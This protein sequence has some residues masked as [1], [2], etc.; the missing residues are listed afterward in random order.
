MNVPGH[1]DSSGSDPASAGHFPIAAIGASAGGLQAFRILLE[2]V[3]ADTR[4]AFVLIPHLD[5]SHPSLLSELLS[6]TSKIPVRDV[7]PG[8]RVEPG[9]AHVIRPN[10]IMTIEDGRLVLIPRDV[11]RG[12]R[13]GSISHFMISLAHT[14]RERAVGVILSGTASDGSEGIEC[15]KAEGGITFAQDDSAEFREMPR[16]AIA[17]GA[18]DFVLPPE[19]IARELVRISRHPVLQRP[20]HS[21]REGS[22]QSP[23]GGVPELIFATLR[24]ATG[25]DFSSYKRSTVERRIARRM[26]ICKTDTL[27]DYARHLGV[28]PREVQHLHDEL[29]IHVTSFFREPAAFEALRASVFPRLIRDRAV[30]DSIRVWVPGCSSGEEGYSLAIALVEFL[31]ETGGGFEVQLFCTDLSER[32]IETARVGIYDGGI[33]ESVSPARLKRFFSRTEGG[34]WQISAAIR[35]RCVFAQ[36]DVT[37]DPPFSRLDLLSCRNVMIYLGPALQ[38]RVISCF[39]YALKPTGFLMLGSAESLERFPSLFVPVDLQH[40][41]FAKVHGSRVD[42]AAS[43]YGRARSR[44]DA[45]SDTPKET[46]TEDDFDVGRTV[47]RLLLARYAPAGIVVSDRGDVVQVR[48]DTG[49]YLKPA[50]GRPGTSVLKMVREDLIIDLDGAVREARRTGSRVSRE[51]VRFKFEDRLREVD[52]EVAPIVSPG[53]GGPLFLVLFKESASRTSAEPKSAAQIP[54][55]R[56]GRDDPEVARLESQLSASREYMRSIVEKLESANEELRASSEETLSA[57]EELQSTNEELETSKEE[58]QSVNEELTTLNDELQHRNLDL[59]QLNSDLANVMAGVNIPLAIVGRDLRLR[60]FTPQAERL[61][62]V[63]PAD[64]GRRITDFKPSV[65]IPD[66][67][68][69]LHEVLETLVPADREVQ[70][71]DGRWYSLRIRPYHASDDRIDGV[72][73]VFVG[74]DA[75]KRSLAE[76]EEGRAFMGAVLDSVR[77][78]FLILDESLRVKMANG[79]FYRTFG[80]PAAEAEDVVFCKL[81]NQEWDLPPLRAQLEGVVR[82]GNDFQDV[83]IEREVPGVGR[84]VLLL[85]GRRV[86]TRSDQPVRVLLAMEDVTE[87]RRAMAARLQLASVVDSSQDAVFTMTLAGTVTSWN[88]AAAAMFGFSAEEIL[89]ET[90]SRVIP[91]ARREEEKR[92]AE[93]VARGERILPYDTIL[94]RKDGTPIEV[95][96]T[97]SPIVDPGGNVIG[98]SMIARDIT[99][100]RRAE[101]EIQAGKNQLEERV[102]ARTLDLEAAFQHLDAFAYTVSHDLRAPLR[103]INAFGEMLI[104][105]YAGRE[106]D[107]TAQ[108]HCRKIAEAAR[109]MDDLVQDLLDYSRLTRTEVAIERVDPQETIANVLQTLDHD[110]DTRGAKVTVDPPIP[111]VMANRAALNQVVT[112]VISNALKF[113]APGVQPRIH[114]RAETIGDRVRLWFE[115]NGIGIPPEQHARVFGVFER[116]HKQEEYPGTGIGL[117]IVKKAIERMGGAVGLESDIGCGCRIRIDLPEAPA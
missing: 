78:P 49:P 38:Q 99:E 83:E 115:D 116:L 24:D 31:N 48:G 72:V 43:A 75:L 42:H 47:D 70:D 20:P 4:M 58:L 112:N 37:R 30:S 46:D 77:D 113:V 95:A 52:L 80:I 96:L 8:V 84:R 21:R 63:I 44:L 64:V 15:I 66:L 1:P 2:H 36:Q 50:P 26:A 60:R 111:A 90:V 25:V 93:R 18:V 74:I 33:S 11:L 110:L 87:M 82:H 45:E 114:I 76:T 19:E 100:R 103:A 32:A 89:E 3:P 10:S 51:G 67:E 41:I 56:Q 104:Q 27:A 117:A 57:N 55:G 22:R 68:Q 94:Q 39:H 59:A 7:E 105:D 5:P 14:C 29:L 102:R 98:I 54:E 88:R 6:R 61:L 101:A 13:R 65:S 69:V 79:A 28:N 92:V 109:R 91:S 9:C 86:R 97:V 81:G 17:T 85:H 106:L 73:L 12:S 23:A 62:N 53:N 34:G 71:A 108:D 107:E 40:R 35:E 16:N